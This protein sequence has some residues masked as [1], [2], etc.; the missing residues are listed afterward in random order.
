M[1]KTTT[2]PTYATPA[3]F[4]AAAAVLAAATAA[5]TPAPAAE[6]N[7][8]P[9]PPG[10]RVVSVPRKAGDHH[11]ETSIAIDPRDA[12]HVI[13]SYQ[14][15]LA[16]SGRWAPSVA[17]SADGGACWTVAADIAPRNYPLAADPTV[18]FDPHG[19][20]FVA[21]VATEHAEHAPY[22]GKGGG[23]N[24]VFARR[25]MD[26]GRTWDAGQSTLIEYAGS[27]DPPFQDKPY[28]V[29]D[30][31]KSSPHAGNLYV[32]WTRFSFDKSEILFVRSTDDGRTW[33][34]PVVISTE[35]GVPRGAASGAVLG[36]HAAVGRDGTVYASWPDGQG[37]VLAVSRDGG[38]T[39]APSRRVVPTRSMLLCCS[40]VSGFRWA[41]GIQT[42]AVDPRRTP[43]KL[44]L[45]WSDYRYGDIDILGSTSE[46]GG[47]TWTAPIRVNDDPQHDGKD[48][49][50]S[51]MAV[52][53]ADGAVYVLFYDRRA[54]PKN[55]LTSM[56]LARSTDGGRT[57]ENYLWS[58]QPSDPRQARF[59][60]YI[61]LAALNGRVYGAWTELAPEG[62]SGED[63]TA[64]RLTGS[65]TGPSVIRIGSA[66][67]GA[68]RFA[69][70]RD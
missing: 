34:A 43:G 41:N 49:V 63:A 31:N 38:G 50:M 18:T 14:Q 36:F 52:D 67:F 19:H 45:T 64:L 56:T 69:G 37:I 24:G 4:I 6:T 33:S 16:A 40:G 27:K 62:L 12:R 2:R 39:F 68:S 47:R 1:R 13:V 25:S 30:N 23:R 58:E 3:K 17:W 26:G 51:W 11:H 42:I 55:A 15:P 66:D 28:L 61:G 5:A 70:A 46:D 59:G 22:W 60:D 7:I 57:F 54:D 21:Y 44:F 48:Q 35:P 32:G 10:A 53:P 9:Q 65:A 29:A 8:L 20:A